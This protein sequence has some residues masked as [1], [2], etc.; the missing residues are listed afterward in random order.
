M[1]L[2]NLFYLYNDFVIS[3]KSDSPI[4]HIQKDFHDKFDEHYLVV[5]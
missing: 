3:K 5:S 1:E 2:F 4:P